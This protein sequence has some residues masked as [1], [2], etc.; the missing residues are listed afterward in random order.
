MKTYHWNTIELNCLLCL[1]VHTSTKL[2]SILWNYFMSS[3]TLTT[4]E[5]IRGSLASIISSWSFIYMYPILLSS[6]Y[7]LLVDCMSDTPPDLFMWISTFWFRRSSC[8]IKLF[9]KRVFDTSP[10]SFI[11]IQLNRGNASTITSSVDLQKSSVDAKTRTGQS[12]TWHH[13]AT[14]VTRQRFYP[15]DTGHEVSPLF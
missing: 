5:S 7:I 3:W 10:Q 14:S 12:L 11:Q 13:S 8:F 9:F 2:R 4:T 6:N 15:S 1:L